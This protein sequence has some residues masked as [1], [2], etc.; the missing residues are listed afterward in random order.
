MPSATTW[1]VEVSSA[2]SSK[3]FNA[4]AIYYL[5]RVSKL[6]YLPNLYLENGKNEANKSYCLLHSDCVCPYRCYMVC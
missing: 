3:R 6:N 1:L 2:P 4:I 5:R